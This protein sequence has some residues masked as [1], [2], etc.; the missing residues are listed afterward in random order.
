MRDSYAEAMESSV[1]C[2]LSASDVER[3]FLS[4]PRIAVR[5]S[6]LLGRR[7]AELETRLGDMALRPLPQHIASLLLQ[8][9]TPTTGAWPRHKLTVR[10]THEQLASLAG[11]TR[12]AV[13]KVLLSFAASGLIKQGRGRITVLQP[14]AL[15][16]LRNDDPAL[17]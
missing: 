15:R 9:A 4:D 10:L 7:V 8:L 2:Q 11:A 13:S 6:Q 5:V 14:D 16:A 3:Y 17:S 12:E 1:V